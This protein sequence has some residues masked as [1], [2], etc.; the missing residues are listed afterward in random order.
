MP[1]KT[2]VVVTK[3]KLD[4]LANTIATKATI[5]LPETID[6][7]TTAVASI[8]LYEEPNLQ[9]KSVEPQQTSQTVTADSGYTGLGTVTVGPLPY[10]LSNDTV[11]A[12]VLLEGYTAHDASGNSITGT[13]SG[14]ASVIY[15][16]EEEDENGGVIKHINAVDISHDTVDAAHLLQGYTAHDRQGNAVTGTYTGEST[17][18]SQT[19]TVTPTKTTQTVTP[20]SGVDYLSSVTVNPIP[21]NYI[22]PTGTKSITS[23]G[24]SDVTSYASVSVN[25][26]P[27]LQ[28]K[29]ATP[30]ESAQTITA[31]SNYD[32]LS[33]V[34]V[35]A[36]S[37]TY[38]GSEVP[39][40]SDTTITPTKSAQEAVASGTYVTGDIT[41]AAIPSQYIVPSGTKTITTNGTSDVTSYAS[42]TVNVPTGSTINN[43]DKTV[44]PTESEQEVTADSGY[45]GLG[46]VT[47]N[48]ISSIYVGSGIDRNDSSD[49]TV[50]G[51]TVTTPAGYYATSASKSVASGTAG[52]PSATKGTVSNHSISITPSVTNTTGYITGGTKTGTAVTVSASELVSGS[53]TIT[54][55]GTTDVT[56]F[57]SVTVNVP[58]GSTINNQDKT[59]TPTESQQSVTADSGYTGLGTVTVNAISDTYVG[60]AIDQND[61]TDLT[62][63][64]ATVSVPAGYY[65]EDASKSVASGSAATPA[66]S[67]TANPSISVSSSGLITA[68]ASA[69]KSV[70]PTVSAGYVSSGTSG[71]ITVSGSNTSQLTTQA[72]KT[73]TPT[74]SSQT[75]VAAGRYTTGAVTVAAIPADYIIPEGSTTITQNGTVDVAEFASAIINVP[76]GSTINNQDKT[77]TPSESSQ[78]IT[79][80][81]GYTGLGTV[82]VNAVSDTYVGSAIDRNDSSDLTVSGAT[83]SVPAGFYE[84]DVSASVASGSAGTPTATKGTVSN[85]SISITPSV[86]NTTGYITGG[87]KTGTAVSVSA[88]ELVS[89]TVT[90]TKSGTTDVT[91]YA[92]AS[93]AAGS[94]S[95]PATTITANPT[96]SVSSSGLITASASASQSVTPSVSAGYVSSGT[97]GTISVS[98]SNTSQLSTQAA[99]TITPTKSS[100]TAVTAGKYTIGAITVAAIPSNYIDT[101]DATATAADINSGET[102]YVNG[103]L[104]TGTQ[105]IQ[106][107]YT[108][109]STPSSSLGSN[110]DIYLQTS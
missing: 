39:T 78:S 82:T 58:S 100:Q 16:T 76:T 99:T 44:T 7:L 102:A 34:T 18:T 101:S 73:I 21:S 67:I 51:A 30:T 17:P 88:S 23:N 56:N 104:V 89:G 64:G 33:S 86:T 28:S 91:N 70:T 90:I 53:T 103:V 87:T 54:S 59:V 5:T 83:V 107:Y 106:T 38:V 14:E 85:H 22:I 60:S 96:I 26:S 35:S 27:S 110:G 57:A 94:A 75:A 81:T 4:T 52:T 48:A 40:Q 50:S 68:T 47:V 25:V 74:K 98:G 84:E 71:T 95:T 69:S 77:V 41:V 49:L 9:N 43:Q 62:V 36:I 6:N 66:T 55:N 10:D 32:G 3:S 12:S 45:T 2:K 11:T 63:S 42:V 108:G 105:V 92:S 72:A 46:T 29:T 79:A 8:R 109:S 24:T 61:S 93:V 20:D 15:V 13:Y 1:T 19:K 97:A 31:D 80:D 65:A 37:K